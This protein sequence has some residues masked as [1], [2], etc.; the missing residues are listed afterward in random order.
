MMAA[1][2]V[3]AGITVTVRE[4]LLVGVFAVAFAVVDRRWE[5][6]AAL[7]GP[8]AVFAGVHHFLSADSAHRRPG[9]SLAFWWAAGVAMVALL[10]AFALVVGLRVF[11][12]TRAHDFHG[13]ELDDDS[14]DWQHGSGFDDFSP[15]PDD[16]WSRP[17]ADPDRPRSV[18]LAS[19]PER[20]PSCARLADVTGAVLAEVRRRRLD[21]TAAEVL[22]LLDTLIHAAELVASHDR[23]AAPQLAAAVRRVED[24]WATVL[25]TLGRRRRRWLRR[26]RIFP[27]SSPPE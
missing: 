17:A 21:L 12:E 25:S 16:D 7:S 5:L 6:A 8:L 19:P 3:R 10:L 15:Y 18:A 2:L 14:K 13:D 4:V 1:L 23:T 22:A 24:Q 27:F 20:A 26:N 9:P 11:R